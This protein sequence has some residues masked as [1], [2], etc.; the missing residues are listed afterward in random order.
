MPQGRTPVPRS[1]PSTAAAPCPG[2]LSPLTDCSNAILSSPLAFSC[3]PRSGCG[4]RPTAR[5]PPTPPAL[6]HRRSL[7]PSRPPSLATAPAPP[8]L[9]SVPGLLSFPAPGRAP[10][11]S[12]A[13][14]SSRH[15]QPP[16]AA[17]IFSLWLRGAGRGRPNRTRTA[18]RRVHGRAHGTAAAA[19]RASPRTRAAVLPRTSAAMTAA[20]HCRCRS[21]PP[22]A[23]SPRFRRPEPTRR[24]LAS[25]APPLPAC[26]G[27][28]GL[29]P[30]PYR[31]PRG[32]ETGGTGWSGGRSASAVGRGRGRPL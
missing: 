12:A 2:A 9:P 26:A 6:P 5:P 13:D 24:R 17:A 8:A 20:Q 10:S 7:T 18:P 3:Q 19:R 15:R 30:E 16:A 28:P 31:G 11:P 29:R 4:L 22:E 32:G 23:P 27:S 21:R 25:A 14:Q 1:L